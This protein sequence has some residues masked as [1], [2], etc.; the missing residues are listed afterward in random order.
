MYMGLGDG[1]RCTL[2][3]F[4]FISLYGFMT[5]T[6]GIKE[7]QDNWPLYRCNPMILPFAGNISPDET[8][9]SENFSYCIQNSISSFSPVLLQPHDYAMNVNTSIVGNLNTSNSNLLAQH[10][11]TS[12]N[13][14]SALTEVFDIF[15]N[16]VIL[17]NVMMVK[18]NDTQGKFMGII[19]SVLHIMTTTN[20]TFG[21]MWNGIPGE[22][23]RDVAS[24]A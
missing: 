11:N 18:L 7:I 2:I 23:L 22:L 24:I 14:G 21:S 16:V 13:A 15:I 9:T 19:T 1:L 17:F 6:S 5:F 4:V 12:F 8:S 3:I 10:S 20:D